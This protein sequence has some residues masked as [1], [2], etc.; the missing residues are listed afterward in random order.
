MKC[1]VS[2]KTISNIN[3]VVEKTESNS[4]FVKRSFFIIG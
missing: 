1:E 4:E 3:D 2:G